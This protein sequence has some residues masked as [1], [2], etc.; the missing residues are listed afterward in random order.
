MA[1]FRDHKLSVKQLLGFIPEAL[2]ANLS[3]TSKVDHYAKVLHGN[4]LFYLL[5]Y[6]ILDNEKLSQRMLEDTFNDRIFKILFNLNEEETVRRSTIS[7]R[8]SKIDPDYFK[9]IY[10]CIY[11]EFSSLY[12]QKA[13]R[14]GSMR[15]C[16][17]HDR[18]TMR[19]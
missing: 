8:L 13:L 10:E 19:K 3:E 2:I 9:Q 16:Y 12:G 4:K 1:I 17:C 7:E 11:E 6:S 18:C 5:L 15:P 14:Y